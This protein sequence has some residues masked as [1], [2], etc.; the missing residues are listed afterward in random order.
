[1]S[2][3]INIDG[4]R[5]ILITFAEPSPDSPI[6]PELLQELKRVTRAYVDEDATADL[7]IASEQSNNLFEVSS[8][9]Q[10]FVPAAKAWEESQSKLAGSNVTV[11]FNGFVQEGIDPT[12]EACTI[13]VRIGSSADAYAITT[14]TAEQV[15]ITI[16]TLSTN[17]DIMLRL[18]E[19]PQPGGEA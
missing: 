3:N 15:V 12:S 17:Q 8:G 19:D 9:N 10:G 11:T 18:V 16:P 13:V 4:K 14:I 2:T 5:Q 6:T 7:V 1:M